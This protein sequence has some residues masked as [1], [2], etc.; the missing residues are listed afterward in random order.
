MAKAVNLSLYLTKELIA[1]LVVALVAVA[2]LTWWHFQT[3]AALEAEFIQGQ[4]DKVVG[5]KAKQMETAFTTVY[6][7]IRAISLLPS[8]RNIDGGNRVEKDDEDVIK[9]KRFTAEGSA[10]VQEIYNNMASQVS[11]SEIYAVVDG[12]N[13]A[14]GEVPFFMYD[15]IRFG[16][17][18]TAAEEEAHSADFPEEAE[19]AEYEYFPTQMAAIKAAHPKFAFAAMDDIPA[20]ASPTMRTCDNTQYQSLKTG[21]AK[22]TFGLL[23]SVPFYTSGGRFRGVISAIIRS[24]VFESLLLNVPLIPVTDEDKATQTKAGWK[25]PELNN[26]A[27]GNEQYGISIHDRRNTKLPENIKAG[28]AERNVFHVQLKVHSDAPWT[29]TYYLPEATIN[30]ATAGHDRLYVILLIVVL[31]ALG[32]AASSVVSL[33]SLKTRLGGKPN[34][35]AL[36]VESISNGNLEVEI[37]TNVEESSVFGSV[38]KMLGKL[39]EV[40]A[41]ARRNESLRVA[42]DSEVSAL[43]NAAADGDFSQRMIIEGKSGYFLTLSEGMNRLMDTSESGLKEVVRVLNA[44]ARGDLTQTMDG[45][46]GGTFGTLKDD[47][48]ATVENLQTLIANIKSAA[49]SIRVAAGEISQSNLDLSQRSEEQ[50]ASL[51]ETAASMEELAST[52]KQNADNARQANEMAVE[53]SSVATKGGELVAGVVQTMSSIN[54]SSGKIVDIISVID[55]IAFQTNILALNAAVEAAR[56]GEQG[57]GFSV[58]AAEVRTLAQ[59][60]AAAAKEIKGLISDSVKKIEGG[61]VLVKDAGQTMTQIVAAVQRVTAIMGE[62]STA[63]LEQSSG[64]EQVNQAVTQMEDVTQQNAARV[65]QAAAAAKSLEEQ[66]LQLQE[67]VSVFRL[68]DAPNQEVDGGRLVDFTG[69]APGTRRGNKG[70]NKSAALKTVASSTVSDTEWEDF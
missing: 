42:M 57:R 56:A 35:V 27:L 44:L 43:I 5:D 53:A 32:A 36:V 2:G 11:V 4:R 29:L 22:E 41:D 23:Y 16:S 58:V 39:Q 46:Y 14:K 6:Q 21:D 20:F 70:K 30:E 55:G 25:M 52:V 68:S 34:E 62:I 28:V 7:N 50:A 37:P 65:E 31:V 1:V 45:E 3:H 66:A 59:R 49:D 61:S 17:E 47:S 26:F 8:V 67:S 15:T 24:N 40:D 10:T 38:G 69:A 48:N 12:L 33:T 9:S 13:A 51:E 18:E 63:S 54:E 60:S 64:I 19:T